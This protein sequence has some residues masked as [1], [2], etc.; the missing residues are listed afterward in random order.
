MWFHHVTALTLSISASIWSP[1]DATDLDAKVLAL[2]L[3]VKKQWLF[4]EK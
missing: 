1:F 3:P 2:G 4:R